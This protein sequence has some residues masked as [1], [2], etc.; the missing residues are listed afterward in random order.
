GR[1]LTPE[2]DAAWIEECTRAGVPPVINMVGMV[3]AA[4]GLL[5]F[6]TAEQR[7]AHLVATARGDEVWGQLFS[8][9][10]AGSDLASLTTRA[11]P[12]GD[13][14]VVTGHKVWSSGARISDFGLLLARTN[15]TAAKHRGISMFILD[16]RLPGIDVRPLRQMTGEADFD[17]VYLDAVRLPADALLGPLHGGWRVAMSA[18]TNERGFIGA[19]VTS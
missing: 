10:D 4:Q 8:E 9:P 17:E 1:G 3:L 6:G 15:P 2:H 11:E 12:D 18:L 7:A 5:A 13:E 19:A 16:M 14:F